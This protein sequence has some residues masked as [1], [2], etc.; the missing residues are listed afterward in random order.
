METAK[1]YV[2]I[3]TLEKWTH[4]IVYYWETQTPAINT[5]GTKGKRLKSK[6]YKSKRMALISWKNFAED[7]A[8]DNYTVVDTHNAVMIL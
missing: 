6:E 5:L 1:W 2:E 4:E 3:E 8:I 7:N